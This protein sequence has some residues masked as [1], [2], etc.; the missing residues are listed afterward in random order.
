MCFAKW[1]TQTLSLKPYDDVPSANIP[2][3][4]RRGIGGPEG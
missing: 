1:F 2:T 3:L 4:Y